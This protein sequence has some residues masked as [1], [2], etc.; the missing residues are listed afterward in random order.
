MYL[1]KKIQAKMIMCIFVVCVFISG[2]AGAEESVEFVAEHLLEVPM[3]TRSLAFPVTPL[4]TRTSEGRLQV[5]YANVSAGKLNNEIGMLGVQFYL[6]MNDHWGLLAGGF[7]DRFSFSGQKGKAVGEVLVVNALNVPDKFDIAITDVSG[8][9]KYTGAS[10]ALT[11]ASGGTWRWHVGYARAEMDI[12]K[13]K[14]NFDTTNLPNNFSGSF[15]YA[16]L[17]K[18]NTLFL[19]LEMTPRKLSENFTYTPHLIIAR[20]SPRVGF[21]GRFTGPNFDYSG[22]TETNGKGTHIPDNYMGVGVNIEHVPSGLRIDLGA[23]LY[24]YTMEPA[25][26]KGIRTPIL[27]TCSLPIF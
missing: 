1:S 19:G 4:N 18:L 14:I 24:N 16:S 5:G 6:P 27:L 11:Y 25:G 9:G 21:Q 10:L 20:N 26:H 17:Y 15:D 22:N 7:Y 12:G 3:D 13:F 2:S 8:S 23:T